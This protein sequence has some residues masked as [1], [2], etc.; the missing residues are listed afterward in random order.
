MHRTGVLM[1]AGVL[2]AACSSP[3]AS[4]SAASSVNVS[5]RPS[6]S[7]F[8]G[9]TLPYI[10]ITF[11]SPDGSFSIGMPGQPTASSQTATTTA[12]PIEIHLFEYSPADQKTA[13][14]VSYNDY[15]AGAVGEP[16]GTLDGAVQGAITNSKATLVQS[17]AIDLGGVPGRDYTATVQGGSLHGHIYL[18]GL[19][20]YQ[21]LVAGSDLLNAVA[22]LN[23]FAILK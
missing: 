1:I 15:P 4:P 13:Y 6:A 3:T 20:L 5:S 7:Q 11:T 21:V 2:L 17:H 12:G 19:R 8:S 23:S 16:Q 22:F 18:K 9:V 10:S 14:V